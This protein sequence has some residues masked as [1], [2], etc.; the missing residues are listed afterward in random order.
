MISGMILDL[1]G[2]CPN[3][4]G[5]TLHRMDSGMISCLSPQCPDKGAAQKLLLSPARAQAPSVTD[6]AAEV[7]LGALRLARERV[8]GEDPEDK[9]QRRG[10][11][12]DLIARMPAVSRPA[13]PTVTELTDALGDPGDSLLR[14]ALAAW[15]ETGR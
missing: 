7:I 1:A 4:C 2:Y 12:E 3:G 13:R 9:K 5:E 15:D 10:S 6:L 8:T 11:L 14:R